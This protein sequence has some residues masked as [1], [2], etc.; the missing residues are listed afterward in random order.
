MRH[1]PILAFVLAAVAPGVA[2]AQSR[3]DSGIEADVN[4]FLGQKSLDRDDWGTLAR[5][6]EIGI[7]S[8]WGAR[9]WPIGV[10]ADLVYSAEERDRRTDTQ[11]LVTYGANTMEL[12][13]GLRKI[14]RFGAVRPFVG[15]GGGF[16]MVQYNEESFFGTAQANGSA[17]GWW[18]NA[19]AFVRL[20]GTFNVGMSVRWSDFRVESSDFSRPIGGGGLH[21][22]AL[23]GF[24]SAD[25]R[26]GAEEP[27]TE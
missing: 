25:P 11:G 17:L 24:G 13:L 23:F 19:G 5:Q 18:A 21:V 9:N 12:D 20:G 22:G 2:A 16:V 26:Q 14:F 27:V 7:E 4:F 8:S 15:A 3:A 1:L 6:T 10:A